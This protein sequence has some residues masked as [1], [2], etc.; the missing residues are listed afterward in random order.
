[1]R[2]RGVRGMGKRSWRPYFEGLDTPPSA[3]REHPTGYSRNDGI[4][5]RSPQRPRCRA[6]EEWSGGARR[7]VK[8]ELLA[9]GSFQSP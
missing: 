5:P 8:R 7:L 9:Y 3:A 2:E 1:M 6:S 4:G